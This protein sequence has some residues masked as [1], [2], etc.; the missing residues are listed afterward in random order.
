MNAKGMR[1]FPPEEKILRNKIVS[2]LVEVF[3]IY[4]FVPLETPIVERFDVLAAKFAAG[5][6]SDVMKEIFKLKDQGDRDLGLRFDL[7]V[8]FARF[9]G[10]NPNIKMP[11]KR[12]QIGEV[13][14]DGPI[15]LGRYREFWQCDVDVVGSE[16]MMSDAE[17][18]KLSLDVFKIL[19]M[20]AYLE[21]NNRKLL[22]GLLIDCGVD[23][24]MM[25][26]VIIIIDKLN[27]IEKVG[28]K[29]ELKELGLDEKI[30]NNIIDIFNIKGN[31]YEIFEILEKKASCDLAIE[32]LGELK[33]LFSYID[34]E[35]IILNLSL[36]RGFSYYT[37][38]LFEGYLRDSSIKSSICG[39][40]RFD[41]LIGM[42]LGNDK[43]YP[44]IGISFGL[45]VISE[46]MKLKGFGKKKSVSKVYI[47]PIGYEKECFD[48]VE[49][50]RD[51]GINADIDIMGRSISKNMKYADAMGI[52]YVV[53]VGEE[54]MKLE[55]VKLRDMKSGKEELVSVD[56]VVEK[57]K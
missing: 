26:K 14:R 38:T 3:E 47:V 12:Y 23:K 1:D 9:V 42:Y 6:T 53:L 52:P 41:N 2:K 19:D 57:L 7:T 50:I 28:V 17:I 36:A 48:I 55:K 18:I 31:D 46:A 44:A 15:K 43:K 10:M 29:N 39:G 22:Q 30:I 4:G 20:D 5:E 49:Q 11:F 40:G 13:F 54:E 37:G 27:K 51:S 8:P 21:V 35:K 16:N 45:D 25:E 24:S 56:E 34:G 33:K 32:G